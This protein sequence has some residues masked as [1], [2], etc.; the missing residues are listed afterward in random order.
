VVVGGVLIV[1]G[2]LV[3]TAGITNLPA[4]TTYT[5][6]PAANVQNRDPGAP[7][8][9][10]VVSSPVGVTPSPDVTVSVAANATVVA[11]LITVTPSGCPSL[12]GHCVV[13]SAEGSNPMGSL[14]NATDYPY[15][16]W[17]VAPGPSAV[18]FRVGFQGSYQVAT[19]VSFWEASVIIA[20]GAILIGIGGV[21]TFLGIFLKGNPYAPKPQP[22]LEG[23]PPEGTAEPP[24]EKETTRDPGKEADGT[25]GTVDDP[26]QWDPRK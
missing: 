15:A 25:G 8:W 9:Q 11:Y 16:I 4:A 1:L 21:A 22:S 18:H 2:L 12:T 26:S 19:G 20:A 23:L 10:F 5:F 7:P 17:V 6:S 14:T 3:L 24:A 13:W